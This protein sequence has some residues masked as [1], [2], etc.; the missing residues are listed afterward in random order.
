MHIFEMR[1]QLR[2]NELGLLALQN[3]FYLN[4]TSIRLHMYG[5]NI[6]TIP[7]PLSFS[8]LENFYLWTAIQHTYTTYFWGHMDVVAVSFED[9]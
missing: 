3:P 9:L 6:I 8:R 4:H 5:V 2:S 1:A 7:T